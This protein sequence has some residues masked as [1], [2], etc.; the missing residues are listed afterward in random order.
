MS[1]QTRNLSLNRGYDRV[2]SQMRNNQ[3]VKYIGSKAIFEPNFIPPTFIPRLK[4]GKYL[5]GSI[6]DALEDNFSSIT[7]IYGLQGSGKNL[8]INHFIQWLEDAHRTENNELNILTLRINCAQKPVE[9][10]FFSLVEKIS[11]QIPI[12]KLW[13]ISIEKLWNIPM[14]KLWNVFKLLIN[15]LEVP[16]IVYLQRAEHLPSNYLN[17]L[18]SFAKESNQLHIL[19]TL[20]TGVEYYAFKQFHNLDHQIRFDLYE[21]DEIHSIIGDRAKMA[22]QQ[23]LQKENIDILVDTAF[24]YD[25]HVHGTSINLFKKL[26]PT[27]WNNS[28]FTAEEFRLTTQHHFEGFSLDYITIAD[29]ISNN[30]FENTLFL[31]YLMDQFHT[32]TDFYIPHNHIADIY[33]DVCDECGLGFTE[34]EF[35][36]TMKQ[37]MDLNILQKSR[38]IRNG[39]NQYYS[40]IPVL[41][42]QEILNYSFGVTD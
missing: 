26:Y 3:I 35:I 32:G 9:Q 6:V 29:F 2:L 41:D 33:H 7:T 37:V 17:K 12:E 20:N 40:P 27:I 30:S 39:Q 36:K 18:F 11:K 42:I 21:Y 13:N 25:I 34:G 4:Q 8:Q 14:Q 19:F 5:A 10:I 1:I 22:L 24:E 28:E 16:V 23:P 31:E 15:K 38:K